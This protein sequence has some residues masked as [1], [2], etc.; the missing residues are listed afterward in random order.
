MTLPNFIAGLKDGL[1]V[2]VDFSVPVGQMALQSAPLPLALAVDLDRLREHNYLL[3][4]DASLSRQ[5]FFLGDDLDFSQPTFNQVLS[6]FHSDVA[7]IQEAS[8][9]R[10]A[11]VKDSM[12]RNA[13]VVYGV[14]QLV[15]SYGETALYLSAMGDPVTGKAPIPYVKSF[16]GE[17]DTGQK[18][19][20]QG[21]MLLLLLMM[22]MRRTLT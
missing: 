8:D 21:K 15:L 18:S 9:G 4:H 19:R 3:E 22:K 11:R 5:D 16:F 7:S 14:R 10:Y 17:S 2:G 6:Y 1:N 12:A 13:K 20:W